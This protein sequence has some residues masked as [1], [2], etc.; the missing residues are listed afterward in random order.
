MVK[1]FFFFFFFFISLKARTVH[2]SEQD[3]RGQSGQ[4]HG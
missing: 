3:Q 2:E 4:G 1:T